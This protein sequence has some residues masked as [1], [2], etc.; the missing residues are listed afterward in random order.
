MPAPASLLFVVGNTDGPQQSLDLDLVLSQQHSLDADVTQHPV[1]KGVQPADHIQPKAETFQ[2]EAVVTDYR[3]GDSSPAPG[4]AKAAMETLIRIRDT[5]TLVSYRSRRRNL[6]NLA[7]S[8]L[9]L[10]FDVRSGGS[11]RFSCSMTQVRI[12]ETRT[13]AVIRKKTKTPKGKPKVDEGT[14]PTTPEDNKTLLFSGLENVG[15][16]SVGSP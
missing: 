5:G 6:D 15:L 9:R 12:V 10:A 3:L 11:L 14:K 4:R 13:A 7:L 1:E 16:L 2:L 8:G